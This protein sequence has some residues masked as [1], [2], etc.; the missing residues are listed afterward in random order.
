[1][2]ESGRC[3][4]DCLCKDEM[5]CCKSV[6]QVATSLH[7]ASRT[8]A[9]SRCL[10]SPSQLT[11]ADGHS[12]GD[13]DPGDA[14]RAHR[15][16]PDMAARSA[17]G[18]DDAS[19]RRLRLPPTSPSDT[20]VQV[21]RRLHDP[22]Q[23]VEGKL[24]TARIQSFML[25]FTTWHDFW[26][27]HYTTIGVVFATKACVDNRK[28][29]LNSNISP[30]CPHNMVNFG[31]LAAEIGWRVWSTPANSNGFRVLAAL[32]QRR[33]STEANQT[34]HDVLFGH[35][36]WYTVYTSSALSS[37]DRISEVQSS[38]CVQVLRYPILAALLHHTP[39]VGVSQNLRHVTRNGITELSQ[40]APPIFGW[41]A[42]TLGIG[43][44]SS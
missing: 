6:P 19:R 28:N 40:R 36:G 16:L 3:L 14:R 34:L 10:T 33:R 11:T 39:A 5:K 18:D 7:R 22:Y 35:L 4:L 15:S 13:D 41:A 37:P 12:D 42:I 1:V 23:V 29:V 9:D 30:T 31:P 8:L 44:H 24:F 20:L 43:P 38:L 27:T 25:F 26:L 17:L 32:L 2:D 21:I